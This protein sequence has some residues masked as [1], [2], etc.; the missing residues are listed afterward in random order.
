MEHTIG[1][2]LIDNQDGSKA[3]IVGYSYGIRYLIEYDDLPGE[4][5][6]YSE[7]AFEWAFRVL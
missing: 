1:T 2:R 6:E 7:S 5:F 4:I 3:K